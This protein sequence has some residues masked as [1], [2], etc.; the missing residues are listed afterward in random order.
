MIYIG[1]LSPWEIT[2]ISTVIFPDSVLKE[3]D[4]PTGYSFFYH[5]RD[6]ISD[7][8]AQRRY[9]QSFETLN[10]LLN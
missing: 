7:L 6:S 5:I 4:S 9:L 3:T 8:Q 1:R 10:E 2:T